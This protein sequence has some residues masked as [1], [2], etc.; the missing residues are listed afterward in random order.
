MRQQFVYCLTYDGKNFKVGYAFN[1]SR[2]LNQYKA[3]NGAYP[4]W[5]TYVQL[6]ENVGARNVEQL[7]HDFLAPKRSDYT[8][9]EWFT[10]TVEE[11][12]HF[13]KWVAKILEIIHDRELAGMAQKINRRIRSEST[14]AFLRTSRTRKLQGLV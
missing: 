10:G 13:D 7:L 1:I 14:E 11:F 4:L 6:P 3:H 12:S 8:F 9:R 5:K 2:R